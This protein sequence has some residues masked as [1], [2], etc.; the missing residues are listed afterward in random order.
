ML[1]NGRFSFIIM[2]IIEI[3]FLLTVVSFAEIL[4][5]IANI[6]FICGKFNL[7]NFC[8]NQFQNDSFPKK[9]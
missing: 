1:G 6:Q 2:K 3:Q 8:G 5:K 9:S 4:L 7:P